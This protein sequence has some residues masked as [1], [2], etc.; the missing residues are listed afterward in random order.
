M[1]IPPKRP[2]KHSPQTTAP[3]NAQPTGRRALYTL[4]DAIQET[5]TVNGEAACKVIRKEGVIIAYQHVSKNKKVTIF[6]DKSFR[7]LVY[8]E[9]ITQEAIQAYIRGGADGCDHAL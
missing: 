4:F 2:K 6:H 5:E 1:T 7:A 3:L 8:S 9:G